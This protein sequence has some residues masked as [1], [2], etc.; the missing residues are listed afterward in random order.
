MTF[1]SPQLPTLYA[2]LQHVSKTHVELQECLRVFR[3]NQSRLLAHLEQLK[4]FLHSHLTECLAIGDIIVAAG[5]DVHARNSPHVS[6]LQRRLVH[7]GR[8]RHP[9]SIVSPLD[10]LHFSKLVPI[11]HSFLVPFAQHSESEVD[12]VQSCLEQN[13]KRI[14]NFDPTTEMLYLGCIMVLAEGCVALPMFVHYVARPRLREFFGDLTTIRETLQEW[15]HDLA[16]SSN[17]SSAVAPFR[18]KQRSD[19]TGGNVSLPPVSPQP[20]LATPASD[21]M[22]VDAQWSL[23]DI[24]LMIESIQS[25]TNVMEANTGIK[26]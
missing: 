10:A 8:S 17:E 24:R 22:M 7:A 23:S 5:S 13:T 12:I 18:K 15:A 11:L 3:S 6:A 21:T 1:S 26:V 20:H 2:K 14:A 19:T 16:D 4:P 9:A 25:S